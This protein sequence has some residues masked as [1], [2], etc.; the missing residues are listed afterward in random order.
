[1]SAFMGPKDS[2]FRDSRFPLVLAG[3]I[4]PQST[5]KGS[6]ADY[7]P[8]SVGQA[9][10]TQQLEGVAK[11]QG[12]AD[13]KVVFPGDIVINSRS[14]RRGASGL[15]RLTG[16]V[17]VVYT[18]LKPRVEYVESRF[19]EYLLKSKAFQD[20][21]Y[22]WGTG[23]VDDLWSTRYDRFASIRIPLPDLATQRR[24]ADRL[25]RET[26]EIDSSVKEL[27]EY[28]GL[29]EKRK[30]S[31][32][33]GLFAKPETCKNVSLGMISSIL[34]G[35]MLDQGKNYGEQTPYLRNTNV[36]PEGVVDFNDLKEMRMTEGERVKLDLRK[37]DILMCEGGDAG[38]CAFLR[39]DAPGVSFQKALLRIRVNNRI[40]LPEYVFHA[41]REAHFSGR[42]AL[43][44][45]VSTIPH[46]TAE[47]AEKLKIYL[48]DLE[49]Q[50][51]IV[52]AINRYLDFSRSIITECTA[53]KELLLK[54]RQVL[55]T[56]M[57]TGKVEV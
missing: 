24:I 1:M 49:R 35:K 19:A 18:V 10:V 43:D 2:S 7:E 40:A 14:D 46:F 34:L 25:D 20:E 30:R 57:V 28:V 51:E 22:R 4:F 53:L 31:L 44:Y 47:K 27:D 32:Y 52:L 55:I 29:L 37:N 38:R 17:S 54:R 56:D 42:I 39:E 26:G 5:A 48:P 6:V 3:S 9:G 16:L 8:L 41:L 11:Q 50:K 36:R 23:I 21:Y 15:S 13:R 33:S 45:S 12:D